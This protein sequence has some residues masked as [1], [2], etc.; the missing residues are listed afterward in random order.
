M[1]A[2]ELAVQVGVA[3]ACQALGVSRGTFYP[4]AIKLALTA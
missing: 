3:P 1:A 2:Q 4:N